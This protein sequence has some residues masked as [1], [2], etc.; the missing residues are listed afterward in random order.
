MKKA[1]SPAFH[2]LVRCS[3]D[4]YFEPSPFF[5]F[6]QHSYSFIN[7][8]VFFRKPTFGSIG[9]LYCFYIFPIWSD[10]ENSPCTLKKKVYSAAVGWSP[11]C[12]PICLGYIVF[13][14]PYFVINFLNTSYIC[15]ESGALISPALII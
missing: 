6:F 4:V 15:F 2:S 1:R 11:K 8:V 13:Q 7:L 10:E 12:F 14:V 9:A 3:I 5:S